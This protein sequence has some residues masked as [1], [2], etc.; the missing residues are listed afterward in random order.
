MSTVK[1]QAKSDYLEKLIK[2]SSP[3]KAIAEL[4][5]N[6]FDAGA[7]KVSVFFDYNLVDG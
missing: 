7:N 5:G 1:V 6:G 2:A 3:I 4:I